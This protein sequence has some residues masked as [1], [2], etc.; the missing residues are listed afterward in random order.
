MLS[1]LTLTAGTANPDDTIRGGGGGGSVLCKAFAAEGTETERDTVC[2]NTLC[3]GRPVG[4]ERND[5]ESRL[6]PAGRDDLP[7]T[8]GGKR[9]GGSGGGE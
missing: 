8:G 4:N 3:R 5:S 7:T 2:K 6:L 1:P 9:R